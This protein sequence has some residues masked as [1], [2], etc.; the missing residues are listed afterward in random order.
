MEEHKSEI[1]NWDVGAGIYMTFYTLRI[2]LEEDDDAMTEMVCNY[3][4][5]DNNIYI[6]HLI[7]SH[8]T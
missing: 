4:I 1:E 8:S 7:N 2:S 5:S 6:F 3:S